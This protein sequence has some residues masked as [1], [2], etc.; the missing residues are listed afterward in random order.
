MSNESEKCRQVGCND[1]LTKPINPKEF[2]ATV[3]QYI[4]DGANEL[5][6]H[7]S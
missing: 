5:T 2:V 6:A 7:R 1:C 4:A 3:S